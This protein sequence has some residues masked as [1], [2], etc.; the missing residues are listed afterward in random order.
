MSDPL[1]VAAC[2]MD[3]LDVS[4]LAGEASSA[5][6][7]LAK[8]CAAGVSFPAFLRF[9]LGGGSTLLPWSGFGGMCRR[10]STIHPI[11]AEQHGVSQC[12]THA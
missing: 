2:R 1:G 9:G 11:S 10:P 5:T 3:A 8:T 12:H 4:I 6:P 7:S